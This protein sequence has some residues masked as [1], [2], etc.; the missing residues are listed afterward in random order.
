MPR[1][2]SLPAVAC[3][4]AVLSVFADDG[5]G[6]LFTS[7]EERAALEAVRESPL[8]VAPKPGPPATQSI[9]FKG[10]I[11]RHGAPLVAWVNGL[12]ATPA[13]WR[14]RSGAAAS[15]QAEGL[16]LRHSRKH[17][18]AGQTGVPGEP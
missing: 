11:L 8:E 7:A 9:A 16:W 2:A 6:R 10:V 17:L 5:L 4:F 14:E 1:R 3:T 15:V 18:K 12:H 13:Q